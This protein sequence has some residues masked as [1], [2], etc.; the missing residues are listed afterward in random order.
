LS[1]DHES[2]QVGID[3]LDAGLQRLPNEAS[4]YISRG[5]LYS[6][7]AQYD[8]A[9]NDFRKAEQL[10]SKQSV[11]SFALDLA[12]LQKNNPEAA[13]AQIRSQLKV[14][15]ESALLHSLLARLLFDQG[16]DGN[17]AKADEALHSA[18]TAVKLKPD[19]L[20]A[21]NL[22]ANIY[23]R[24]GKY[25]LAAEECRRTLQ[26]DPSDQVAIYHLIVALRHANSPESREQIQALVKRLSAL[27]AAARQEDVDRKRF[28]F[29]E[30]PAPPYTGTTK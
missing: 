24:A 28:K 14:H 29:V 9:E 21:R 18:L 19:L 26:Y 30:Q 5:M 12:Q 11:T 10:D 20:E 7:L 23:L 8:R 22:L 13:I 3:M 15:P 2:Y 17:S 16:A 25:D 27:Q 1:L 6:Q 4:L